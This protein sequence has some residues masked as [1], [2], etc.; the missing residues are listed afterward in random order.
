MLGG[1]LESGPECKN[2][3]A[4]LQRRSC[5]QGKK[6]L[7][8]VF[9]HVPQAA[10][11]QRGRAVS[12]ARRVNTRSS[13]E[14]PS[15]WQPTWRPY[16]CW[17]VLT[18]THPPSPR[19]EQPSSITLLDRLLFV[20]RRYEQ[21]FDGVSTGAWAAMKRARAAGTEWKDV[22]RWRRSRKGRV[23]VVRSGI[24]MQGGPVGPSARSL[25]IYYAV[26][27]QYNPFHGRPGVQRHLTRSFTDPATHRQVA[28]RQ[29]DLW[30]GFLSWEAIKRNLLINNLYTDRQL[31]QLDVHYAFLSA[32]AHPGSDHAQE[33][34]HGHNFPTN[35]P[36]YDH[37]ASELAMLYVNTLAAKELRALKTMSGRTP[38]VTIRGWSSVEQHVAHAEKLS[39]YLWFPGGRPHLFDKVEEANHRGLRRGRLVPTSKRVPPHQIPDRN[40]RY[41]RNPL[42]R[43]VK[44]HHSFSELTGF[45]YRSPWPRPD[46]LRR[47]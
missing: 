20:G 14:G 31:S 1:S 7:P 47:W 42:L 30:D 19:L 13:H 34:L 37:F 17:S 4:Q 39:G 15:G 18:S 9:Q 44:M 27:G 43:L 12:V 11:P 33:L 10:V 32:F 5:H 24:H 21:V 45:A 26:F 41:Y 8:L 28:L 40:V 16:S 6:H 22:I 2:G 3:T 38:Q 36:T 23:L 35:P 46:S 25:S 29:R